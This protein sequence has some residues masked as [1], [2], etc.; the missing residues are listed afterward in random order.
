M[1]K[2]EISRLIVLLLMVVT[3]TVAFT[4]LKG[5]VSNL[6]TRQETTIPDTLSLVGEE[7][8]HWLDYEPRLE[9]VDTQECPE[10]S[11]VK[12]LGRVIS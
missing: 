2:F 5:R 10:D 6:E 8:C 11:Y 4:Q 1:S 9:T 3:A 7:R 12:G